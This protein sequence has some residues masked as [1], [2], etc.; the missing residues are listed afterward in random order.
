MAWLARY[1]TLKTI[2]RPTKECGLLRRHVIASVFFPCILLPLPFLLCLRSIASLFESWFKK[3]FLECL[4]TIVNNKKR[5]PANRSSAVMHFLTSAWQTFIE[6]E[7][8]RV[9]TEWDQQAYGML[10]VFAAFYVISF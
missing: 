1:I 5:E 2:Q 9:G 10:P 7:L 8:G 6:R 3:A 4:L